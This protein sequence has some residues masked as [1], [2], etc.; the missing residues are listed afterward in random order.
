VEFCIILCA[1]F[2]GILEEIPV[3]DMEMCKDMHMH[4]DVIMKMN[5]NVNV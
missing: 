2:C 5:M 1:T 4:I 3:L